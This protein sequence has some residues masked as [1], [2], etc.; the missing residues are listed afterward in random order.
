MRILR[1]CI[2]VFGAALIAVLAGC[3]S[4][5]AK[6]GEAGLDLDLSA[7][8]NQGFVLLKVVSTRPISLLNPKWQ[9]ISVR[10]GDKTDAMFDITPAYSMLMGQHVPTESLYFAKLPAGKY[11]I[12]EMGSVGPGP[13]LLLALLASDRAEADTQ[14]PD[15]VV[16]AG[17]LANL[18]TI[19]YA[20][21]IDKEQPER[22]VLLHGPMGKRAAQEAFLAESNRA[23][24]PLP[25]GG[26]WGRDATAAAELAALAQARPLVS[27]LNLSEVSGGLMAGS[28]LGQIFRR[29]G[30]QI[31]TTEALDSLD[32]VYSFGKTA[33]GRLIAGNSYGGYLVES[34][35][36]G[37]RRY[38]LGK[39]T[40][41]VAHIETRDD[42]SVIF[43]T[44][45][46]L[47]SKV[48]FKKSLEDAAEIPTEVATVETPP[49]S[50]LSNGKEI[51]LA[52]KITGFS[53][54]SLIT[55]IDKQSLAVTS[56]RENFWVIGWQFLADGRVQLTR[57]N[58]MSLYS[59]SSADNMRTWNH[60]ERP[61]K[62]STVWLDKKRAFGLDWRTGFVMI[63]NVL[64][65]T[66]NGGDTWEN[67]GAP[68]ETKHFAGRI[69]YADEGEI[70]LQGGHMLYSST[71][72]GKTWQR[73]F[74]A[75]Q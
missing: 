10:S 2:F 13:G 6:R 52:W 27:M 74:P 45:S 65:K 14:L 47:A 42:G 44:G 63:T 28:H 64:Q 21:E 68:M 17:R 33:D 55:R 60:T 26:G 61:G 19:V 4:P 30:P 48:W 36:G 59:S 51:F 18:G 9:S 54:E 34:G 7:T 40:G 39:E 16:E 11:V 8:A 23:Q 43:I 24:L 1:V 62:L 69:V 57:Q 75:K 72:E 32:T 56:Q 53:R 35:D 49:D 41:R 46:L 22:M 31:W 70:L 66:T 67:I 3:A 15:F 71:N 5:A 37:W 58:G 73:L 12:S 50:I 38:R 20:P 29:A 25:E